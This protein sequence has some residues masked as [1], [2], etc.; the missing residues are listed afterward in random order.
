MKDMREATYVL[1]IKIYRDRYKRLHVL[2][3]STYL[4]KMLKQFSMKEFKR[5][6]LSISYRIQICFL[7]HKLREI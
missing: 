1:E 3:Q 2:L 4:D 5:G 6:Y 7:K